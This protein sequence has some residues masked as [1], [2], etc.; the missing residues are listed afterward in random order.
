MLRHAAL[1]NPTVPTFARGDDE[2]LASCA[3][4]GDSTAHDP[5]T[6]GVFLAHVEFVVVRVVDRGGRTGVSSLER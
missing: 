1:T 4:D 3:R 6:L 2:D 5:W